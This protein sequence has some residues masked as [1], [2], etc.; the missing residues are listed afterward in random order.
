MNM[1]EQEQWKD[2][3]QQ[4]LSN[5]LASTVLCRRDVVKAILGIITEND[6]EVDPHHVVSGKRKNWLYKI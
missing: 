3:L 5:I 2:Q 6:F 1:S 4:G